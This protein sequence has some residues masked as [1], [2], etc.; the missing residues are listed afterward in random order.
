MQGL[1]H[2][3]YYPEEALVSSYLGLLGVVLCLSWIARNLLGFVSPYVKPSIEFCAVFYTPETANAV[4]TSG[5]KSYAIPNAR[6]STRPPPY[7]TTSGLYVGSNAGVTECF[8]LVGGFRA[9][10]W[11]KFQLSQFQWIAVLLAG[12]SGKIYLLILTRDLGGRIVE[13]VRM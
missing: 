4:L 7:F 8:P 2:S 5:Q 13:W 12:I 3:H 6:G 9:Y 10:S 1:D 11:C